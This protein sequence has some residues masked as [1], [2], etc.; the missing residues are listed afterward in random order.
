MQSNLGLTHLLR[1]EHRQQHP[2]SAAISLE[3]ALDFRANLGGRIWHSEYPDVMSYSNRMDHLEVL[4]KKIGRLR[5]EI[6]Q[7]QELNEQY[8]RDDAN[9]TGAQVAHG[10]KHERLQAIQQE[11]AQL[12]SLGR[13]VQ[14]IE[15][16]KEKHRSRLNSVKKAS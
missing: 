13:R 10:Q 6:A 3:S 5:M 2:V 12:A 4:R 16:V 14:S 9:E 7:I 1:E 15:E 8:R 11:L